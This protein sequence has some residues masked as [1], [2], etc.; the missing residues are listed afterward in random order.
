MDSNQLLLFRYLLFLLRTMITESKPLLIFTKKFNG[1]VWKIL[2]S[3]DHSYVAIESRSSEDK[4]VTFSTIELESGKDLIHDLLLPE[5]WNISMAY[6]ASNCLILTLFDHSLLPER[7][8]IISIDAIEGT[9][10]WERFNLS[11]NQADEH[12]LIVYDSKIQPKKYYRIDHQS[13]EILKDSVVES[14]YANSVSFPELLSNFKLP[15]GIS[16]ELIL[17]KISALQVKDLEIVSFH[18]KVAGTEYLEQRLLVYQGDKIFIDD[19]LIS[20]I[21]KLQP[22]SF[23]ISNNRLF[24]IRSKSEIV[25]YLV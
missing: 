22:E 9:I 23:F 20:G 2:I 4:T 1:L 5:T 3:S 6:A 19:I 8:G 11:L 18:Q 16:E 14:N 15:K 12:G 24:Y 10:N 7:K 21:Q 13:A 17:G 25:S